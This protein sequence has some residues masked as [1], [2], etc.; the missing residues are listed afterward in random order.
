MAWPLAVGMFSYT[1]LGLADTLLMGRVGTPEQAGVGLAATFAFVS[2]SF[3]RGVTSGA[4][5]LV[6]AADG[7]GDRR[8]VLRAATTGVAIGALCGVLGAVAMF[9]LT[10][11]IAPL[12]S[13]VTIAGPA[14]RYLGIRL[15]ELPFTLTGL[16][17]LAA[18]QGLGDTKSRMWIS[19]AGNLTNVVLDVVLIFGVG[20]IPAMAERGAAIATVVSS[21][22][23]AVL[24]A[25]RF[26]KLLGRLVVPTVEVVRSCLKIGLPAG[27]QGLLGVFA[28]GAMNLLL[29][30]AGASELA[31]S[32]IVINIASISFL[33]GFGVSEACGVLVGRYLGKGKRRTAARTLRSGRALALG[34]MGVCG[35]FFALRGEWFAGFF[36]KDPEVVRL[37]STLLLFAASFQLFDAVAMCHLCTLRAIGDTRFSLLVTTVAAWGV[38]VPAT[39]F[40]GLV[41]GWG[42]KGAW[43]GLTGEI[44]LLALIT[45]WRV[46]GLRDGRLGRMDLLLGEDAGQVAGRIVKVAA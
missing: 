8:R 6:A 9:G 26:R 19:M 3:F 41:L 29:A 23:M 39:A 30:R 36:S 28:F 18:L 24:Y 32:Q 46:R 38:T 20:P 12:T 33:P 31:A 27:F 16:G 13:D 15:F 43:F 14:E 25:W 17:L 5:S 10:F 1:L 44:A 35:L 4:Q 40:F 45:G 7:A 34:L 37:A 21:V 22:V 2:I 42:A 11:V